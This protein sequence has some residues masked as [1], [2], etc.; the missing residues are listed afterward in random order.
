[1]MYRILLFVAFLILSNF[2]TGQIIEDLD[3]LF[4]SSFK[5]YEPGGSVVILK[6]DDTVYQKSFGVSDIDSGIAIDEHTIFNTGSIS[7]TFVA[8]GILILEEE[9]KLSIEDPILKY[10]P[11]FENNTLVEN[12]K[13]KHLLSHSSGLP[14]IR[15]VSNNPEFYLDA[16]DAQNFEPIKL[17]K[18]L[19]F[20]P[21]SKFQYSNPAFN[22]LAIIIEQVSQMKWQDYIKQKIFDPS[23]MT[24]SRIT[25]G[26][27]PAVDVAHAYRKRFGKY[28]E[29]DY[30]EYPTFTA[31]GNGGVWCSIKD[32]IKYERAIEA[33]IFLSKS[34]ILKSR[35]IY[36]PESWESYTPPNLG[37]S[38]FLSSIEDKNTASNLTQIY[39][40]GSQGGFRSFYIKIPE[41]DILYI[42][43]FNRPIKQFSAFIED[44][45]K[46]LM[47]N[48]WLD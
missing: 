26:S 13:I 11:D 27:L 2:L 4:T 33:N 37:F 28:E 6:G 8:Y 22:G 32:L 15:N 44:V 29:Y 30:G 42:G 5:S 40:T 48:N 36:A 35:T 46:I 31:A 9:G 41:K 24:E 18:R 23:G 34:Q 14:D 45:I 12:I 16:D 20:E 39:H 43:L 38:W 25:D 10:F 47:N 21:G 1:M 3:K 7:K 19:N 17:A